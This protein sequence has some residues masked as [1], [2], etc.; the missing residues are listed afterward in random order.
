[1]AD[2]ILENAALR[3]VSRTSI[4]L[5]EE[6]EAWIGQH[7]AE[8]IT[9]DRLQAVACVSSRCLQKAC[10][11]RWGQTPL[12]LVTSRRLRAA[13]ERL[14]S[15]STRGSVTQAALSSGFS[16]L[17]RFAGLYKRTFGESPSDTASRP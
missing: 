14:Q 16:H 1:M 12:E 17:G 13:R 3:Q 11:A 6:I 9:L 4:R 2:I 8:P 5:A 10:L 15:R 7:L